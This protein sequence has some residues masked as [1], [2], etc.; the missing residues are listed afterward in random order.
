MGKRRSAFA[1]EDRIPRI[2]SAVRSKNE[3]SFNAL[4]GAELQIVNGAANYRALDSW[5]NG[6]ATKIIDSTAG[7]L[8]KQEML[9][10]FCSLKKP[11]W[12]QGLALAKWCSTREIGFDVGVLSR[13]MTEAKRE[14]LPVEWIAA[15]EMDEKKFRFDENGEMID[16]SNPTGGSGLHLDRSMLS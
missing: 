16:D 6:Q 8:P 3:K 1:L 5:S 4:N 13:V 12:G 10:F 14:K 2:L 7:W 11:D 9:R 15:S